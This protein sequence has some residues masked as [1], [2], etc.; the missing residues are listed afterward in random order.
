MSHRKEMPEILSLKDQSRIVNDVLKYRLENL[1]PPIM[2]E[3]GFDMW[4]IICNEDNYDPVFR[5]MISWQCWAPILQI[6]V[7]YDRGAD[8]GIERL[9]IS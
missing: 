2:R 1:L 6:V 9:N 7:I 4:L 5:T 3:C 8:K